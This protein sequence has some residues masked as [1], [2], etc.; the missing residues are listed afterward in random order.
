MAHGPLGFFL[1]EK[2]GTTVQ[3][4]YIDTVGPSA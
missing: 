4:E 3:P 2:Y 1:I